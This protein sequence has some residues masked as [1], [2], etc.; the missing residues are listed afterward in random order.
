[1]SD[2]TIRRFVS[3]LDI[4]G[5]DA[6]AWITVKD[7]PAGL[8][9]YS[10][11]LMDEKKLRGTLGNGA[12]EVAAT[13]PSGRSFEEIISKLN[14]PVKE[15]MFF[16]TASHDVLN[17]FYQGKII[18][19]SLSDTPRAAVNFGADGRAV[20][21]FFQS[22]DASSAPHELYHIFRREMARTAADP[23]ASDRVR[24]D[25]ARIEEFVGAKPR[26]TWTR[27]MEEKF[28]KAGERFLLEGKAP[29]PELQGVFKRLRRWFLEIYANADAAGLKIS[30]A[31]RE[32]FGNMLTTPSR[33]GDRAFS[34]AMGQMTGATYR[35]TQ[36]DGEAGLAR[37]QMDRE[38]GSELNTALKE[39]TSEASTL[40]QAAKRSIYSDDRSV[41]MTFE[42]T[43]IE[44]SLEDRSQ[45]RKYLESLQPA[46]IK[47]LRFQD[48]DEYTRVLRDIVATMF[49]EGGAL[50]FRKEGEIYDYD[51]FLKDP[52][53][54]DYVTTLPSTL[55]DEDIRVEFTTA[56]GEAKAYLIKK[57][58]D[59]E[60]QKD[61]WDLLV[62]WDGELRTKFA[63]VGE[64][65]G[66]NYIEAQIQGA[67][68]EASRS[69]TPPRTSESASPRN[70]NT[71]TLGVE[72]VKVKI[73]EHSGLAD[74]L[75]PEF[76]GKEMVR[77]EESNL[78][79]SGIS[80]DSEAEGQ[81]VITFFQSAEFSSAPHELY[82]IF[83]R[84][85]ARTAADPRASE[86]TRRDWAG[87]EEFV[88]AEPRQAWT[89]DMEEKFAKAGERFIL[90]GKTPSPELQG[91]FERL[92][93]WF[94]EIY[95]NADA[96]GLEISP[97]MREVFG[98]M[99][100]T[101]FQEGDMAFR[102]ALGE[103]ITRKP[104]DDFTSPAMRRA[105]KES[106]NAPETVADLAAQADQEM[107]DAMNKAAKSAPETL[108]QVSQEYAAAL[109][110]AQADIEKAQG[111]RDVWRE[112]AECEMR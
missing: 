108:S 26:Q 13:T 69:A 54:R 109:E 60:V 44:P 27:D 47:A 66:R 77:E 110:A 1:M 90:E 68:N 46:A 23:R 85:M 80:A 10:V 38:N 98:N 99:L 94:L 57:Y 9:I 45:L 95:A 75:E 19:L 70:G 64:R 74:G 104:E 40:F 21:T 24:L 29:S 84:E 43:A 89:R 51:H 73:P 101:P 3:S 86:Q 71:N 83:R 15:N 81:A 82:S 76:R 12:T 102:R 103:M 18:D 41:K 16:Q 49:P 17:T 33:G 62:I 32:V 79:S 31:M 2:V 112:I 14:D 53:R 61:V 52:T 8:R 59:P 25:W 88:G 5:K 63:R 4:N 55:K 100:T 105:A 48:P 35:E 58:F 37:Q 78:S 107:V 87:V 67:G 93:W 20:I 96:A 22:V 91:V 65:K 6:F 39:E 7:T 56:E 11:E 42:E 36:P 72:D 50:R 28:S 92:R 111:N 97:A 34:R 106:A 30:P